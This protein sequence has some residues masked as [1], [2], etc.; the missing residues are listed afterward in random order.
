MKK[1]SF[2]YV[3]FLL[4]AI[5]STTLYTGRAFPVFAASGS[6]DKEA[7]RNSSGVYNRSMNVDPIG[8]NEGFS[9]VVYDNSNGLPTSEANAIVET[10]DGFIWIGSYAG[11]IRYDG[12][13]FERMDLDGLASIKCLYVDSKDRLWIGTNDNG[14]ALY[15]RGELRKWS[16]ADG[17]KS[18]H[19]RAITEGKD[20]SIY[21]ATTIGIAIIDEEFKVTM[22]EDKDIAEADM[23]NLFAG[24]DDYIFGTTNLG[25]MMVIKD[26]KLLRYISAAENPFKGTG[27]ILPDP[28][29]GQKLYMEAADFGLYHVDLTNGFDV[30]EKIEMDPL[31]YLMSLEYIDGKI[32]ICAGNGIGVVEDG[33]FTFLDNLPLDSSVGHVMT[34]YLGNLWFTS[35][36]EGVMKVVPNQFSDI[37]GRFE[38]PETVVNSTCMSDGKL[39]AGTDTGLIVID[40]NG[41][42]KSYPLTKVIT[43][44]GED[45]GSKNLIKL[46]EGVRIRSI[47]SDSKGRVWIST[48][49]GYG[50]LCLEGG[51]LTIYNED[52]GLLSSSIRSVY[53]TEDGRILT[54][55]IGGVN[56]LKD[57]KVIESIGVEDGITNEESLTVA[58]GLNGE[59]LVGSNG[60]GLYVVTDEGTKT[61]NVEEGLPS[62]IVMRIKPDKENNVVW[63]ITSSAIAY[64]TPDYKIVTI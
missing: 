53:E 11:L 9:A 54:A 33:K 58:E 28:N 45:L 27:A 20:G 3:L 43:A 50:L 46:L 16:K 1:R 38:I 19:T 29:G 47:I 56:I 14:I 10:K 21:V 5:I 55:L 22:M 57:G 63:I 59:I 35:T 51:A 7:T 49:R 30:I 25:D 31:R 23:R 17:L 8:G 60:G 44:S 15:E 36:R 42:L 24:E 2:V 34:D 52:N 37:F 12:N 4:V 40:E 18:T 13:T 41:P 48:W 64:M 6:E 26:K 39:F 61:I 32:W 62:D